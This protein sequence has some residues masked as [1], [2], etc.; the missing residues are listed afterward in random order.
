MA[1]KNKQIWVSPNAWNG[2]KVHKPWSERAS[3]LVNT[4]AEANAIAISIAK[5]QKL[6]TKVQKLDWIIQWWN[7]YWNDPFP[8]RD[9]NK[10]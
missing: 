2:W 8:P 1:T 7:S 4:K 10:I 5:N 6:E 9:K 3:A